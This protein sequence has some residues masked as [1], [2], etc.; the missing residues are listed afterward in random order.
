MKLPKNIRV[1]TVQQS[2]IRTLSQ[3]V[4]SIE[5]KRKFLVKPQGLR[6]AGLL[7]QDNKQHGGKNGL[8]ERGILTNAETVRR[9]DSGK[10]NQ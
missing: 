9:K 4:I 6:I 8:G 5:R 2:Y 3:R 1:T 7:L 10:R